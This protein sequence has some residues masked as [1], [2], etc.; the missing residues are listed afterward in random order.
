MED[1]LGYSQS[2]FREASFPVKLHH[3]L[4]SVEEECNQGI[5]SWQPH[6]RAFLVF[7]IEAFVNDVLPK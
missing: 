2:P 3:M 6:G 4:T 7:D 1:S 5:V